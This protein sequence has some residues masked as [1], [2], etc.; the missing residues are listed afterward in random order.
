MNNCKPISIII[1]TMAANI[2]SHET[3]VIDTLTNFLNEAEEY[4]RTSINTNNEYVIKNPTYTGGEAENFADKWAIHPERK[5]S[6]LK[7][8]RKA[9]ND[10]N[11][12]N[13]KAMNNVE[14][15]NYLKKILGEKNCYKSF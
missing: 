15:A 12:D 1:T 13:L 2:Y 7:W 8:I 4:L 11:L 9:K 6:F 3:R 5:E 10:F 14:L